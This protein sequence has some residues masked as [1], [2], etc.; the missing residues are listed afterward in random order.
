VRRLALL[1]LACFAAAL[2]TLWA[3][4]HLSRA[5]AHDAGERADAARRAQVEAARLRSSFEIQAGAVAAHAA[6]SPPADRLRFAAEAATR[7]AALRRLAGA[8]RRAGVG[9]RSVEQAAAA[10]AAWEGAA[11]RA[12]A[13]VGP[14]TGSPPAD[15]EAVRRRLAALSGALD[16]NADEAAGAAR[17]RSSSFA[18]AEQLAGVALAV[19][20]LVAVWFIRRAFALADAADRRRAREA[21]WN[22]QLEAVTEWSHR[23]K[24][25]AS[26]AQVI[27]FAHTLPREAIGAACVHAAEGAPAVHVSHGRARLQVEVDGGGK[28]LHLSICFDRDRG[29]ELDNHAVQVVIGHLS[30]LWRTVLRQE[31]LERDAGHDP[32]TGLP[33][34]RLFESELRRRIALHGRRGLPFALAVVDLDHFKSVNDN[35]GHPEGDAVLRRTADALRAAL[36]SSDHVFRLGGEEFAL[37]LETDDR[38]G[39]ADLLDR[40]RAAV[41]DLG[42]EPVP[43]RLVSAS[44]GWAVYPED[45]PSRGR[46]VAA[47][48]DAVYRAKNAGRDRVCRAGRAAPAETQAA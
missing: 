14:R 5:A 11:S 44:V 37:I 34:R 40:A 4:D 25:A 29:D 30:A 39:V 21:R 9:A 38:D 42:V 3:T 7:P 23:A 2:G 18:I 15:A 33:N 47:A 43:G 32:L 22:G 16:R 12:L 46:L 8:V 36:R 13:G 27:G 26:R 24:T 1:W 20:L 19:M 41:K 10:L 28:G 6:G 17:N 45:A 48:D 35:L 31:Q